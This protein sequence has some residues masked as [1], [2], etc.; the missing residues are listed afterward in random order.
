MLSL[1]ING[2]KREV[3]APAETPLLY[4]LRGELGVMSV[5]FGCGLAQCGACSVLL[6]GEE[7]RACVT[8]VSEAAGKEVTTVDGLA[9]RWA[10]RAGLSGDAAAATLHPVQQAWID[11]QVPQC[12]FCHFGMMMKATELL[13]RNASPS[14]GDI[15]E[16][17][18]T[19]GPSPHLCRCGSYG[20]ISRRYPSGLDSD[21][22]E[23]SG[24][25]NSDNRSGQLA[26]EARLSRRGFMAAGGVLAVSLGLPV[27]KARAAGTG[28]PD[29]SLSASW[30]EIKADNTIVY[31]TGKCDFGQSTIYTA[32][33]QIIAEELYVPFAAIT[34]VVSGDTD[35]TPDGGG[36]FGLLRT[37]AMNLRKAAAYTR[38]ALLDLAAT[39]LGVPRAQVSV[40]DGVVSGGG[41]SVTYGELV[42]GQDLAL[43]IP[44]RGNPTDFGGM[45]VDGNPPLKPVS[46]YTIVGKPI[47]NR[48]IAPKVTG[49]TTWVTDVT[50]P[51]MLHGR[52][53]HAGHAGIEA[54]ARRA[55]RYQGL[56][57]RAG[58][59]RRQ[60]RRSGRA[61]RMGSDPG[62]A[63][64]GG[65]YQMDCMERASRQ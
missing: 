36:T 6:D 46:A 50:V 27:G 51:G 9:D 16:A 7:V 61:D 24:V 4:V 53:V 45:V 19:S 57:E 42:K 47:A 35:R 48:S 60:F 10:K 3:K 8:P 39:H 29:A 34:G 43:A 56:P 11:E 5:K 1:S 44:V 65:R 32:Y 31:H 64:G 15:N 33:P 41:K 59:G 55:A 17:L 62:L 54:G 63:A 25:M 22:R 2:A 49:K 14:D 13:E 38:E 21:E 30:F 20:A 23:G 28:S 37:N 52:A 26:A 12:G 18:T 58:R 40:A